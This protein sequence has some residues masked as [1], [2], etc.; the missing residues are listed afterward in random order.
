MQVLGGYQS[1]K[2]TYVLNLS[3]ILAAVCAIPIP[4][5]D[6]FYTIAGLYWGLLFF[7]GFI[8]P[9]MTGIMLSSVKSY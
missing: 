2:S 6:N 9:P 4:L 5:L 8:L 1:K 3:G 7:G